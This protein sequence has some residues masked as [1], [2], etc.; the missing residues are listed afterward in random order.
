MIITIEWD[1]TSDFRN[2]LIFTENDDTQS[3]YIYTSRFAD[4]LTPKQFCRFAAGD[5]SLGDYSVNKKKFYKW[6]DN[7]PASVK[8]KDIHYN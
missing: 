4:L 6:F 7:L 2:K 5:N 3:W 8:E 1:C